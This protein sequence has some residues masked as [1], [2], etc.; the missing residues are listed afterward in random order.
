VLR[1]TS[2]LGVRVSLDDFRSG[3]SALNKVKDLPVDDLKID[4]SFIDGLVEDAVTDSIVRLIVNFVHTLGREV[5]PKGWR[6]A[7]G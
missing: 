4:K 1:E 2:D 3:F 7:C 5:T 6:T